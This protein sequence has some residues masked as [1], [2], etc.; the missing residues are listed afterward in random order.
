MRIAFSVIG[1]TLALVLGI[2]CAAQSAFGSAPIG[3]PPCPHA[4]PCTPALTDL[5]HAPDY[6]RAMTAQSAPQRMG[7]AFT[8]LHAYG[9][10]GHAL[11][12][13]YNARAD[14]YTFRMRSGRLLAAY[15]RANRTWYAYG[16]VVVV[17]WRA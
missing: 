13:R 10:H 8:D 7:H 12:Q 9:P 5:P 16:L 3:Y 11:V 14:A 2:A 6:L 17:G 15:D 4:A 1:C